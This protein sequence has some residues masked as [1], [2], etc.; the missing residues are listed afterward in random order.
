M[1]IEL[2]KCVD[3]LFAIKNTDT[4]GV[5]SV[6]LWFWYQWFDEEIH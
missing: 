3:Q 5:P 4:G 1:H 2:H 6:T